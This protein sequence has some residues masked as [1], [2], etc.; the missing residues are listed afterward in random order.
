[1]I[2][3]PSPSMVVALIALTVALGGTSYAAIKLPKNSVGAK[4][5]KN[6][7]VS[8]AKVKDGSLFANDF[9]AG[10]LP[11]GAKGDTGLTGATGA[12]GVQGP[13]GVAQVIVRRHP[14]QVGIAQAVGSKVSLVSTTLPAGKWWVSGSTNGLYD[15]AGSTF[16]CYLLV[17]GTTATESFQAMG[18][19]TQAGAG[20]TRGGVFTPQAAL[21]LAAPTPV[22]LQCSH[23][24]VAPP[25]GFG[26]FF[27][28]SQL[29]AIRADSLDVSDG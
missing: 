12:T 3:R 21:T 28:G 5:I 16:N 25:S 15:G 14:E 29:M 2:H 6:N 20:M 9:A 13:P 27:L 8:G 18:L 10:Q 4:Q 11:R 17:N 23:N 24:E 7:A 1:V 22:V 26:P 19:G